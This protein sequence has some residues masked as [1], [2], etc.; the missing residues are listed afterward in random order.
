MVQ[1]KNQEQ[2]QASKSFQLLR[3][4]VYLN[5]KVYKIKKELFNKI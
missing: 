5:L 1:T 3:D 4:K 2:S